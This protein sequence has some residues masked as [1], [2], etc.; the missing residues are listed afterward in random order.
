MKRRRL[1]NGWRAFRVG[2]LVICLNLW[3]LNTE[4]QVG[5]MYKAT[6]DTITKDAFYKIELPPALVAKCRVDLG[7]LRILEIGRASCR[8]RVFNWV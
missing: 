8:E 1:Y 5:F 7:D 6:L 2:A 3:G 4:A